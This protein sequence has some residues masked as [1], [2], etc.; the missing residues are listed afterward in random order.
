MWYDLFTQVLQGN[1]KLLV[2]ESHTDTLI[3][4]PS[5]GHNLYCKYSNGSCKPILDIYISRSFQLYKEPFNLMSFGFSNCFSKIWESIGIPTPKVRTHVGSFPHIFGLHSQPAPF[6][7]PCL[8]YE[9]K[10]KVVM[11]TKYEK[12]NCAKSSCLQNLH[13]YK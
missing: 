2:V 1:F 9:P 11:M 10:A 7:A 12:P 4:I 3:L 5:F 6:H 13:N 8:G